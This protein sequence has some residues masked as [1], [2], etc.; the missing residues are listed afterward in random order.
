VL[1]ELESGKHWGLGFPR[2]SISEKLGSGFLVLFINA[3]RV[4]RN[5]VP[6]NA[7]YKKRSRARQGRREVADNERAEEEGRRVTVYP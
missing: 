4:R 7:I 5:P 2:G 6:R 3:L 1:P